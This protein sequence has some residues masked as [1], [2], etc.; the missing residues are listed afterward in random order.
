MISD[1]VSQAQRTHVYMGDMNI[2]VSEQNY[3]P[4]Q[5]GII[6]TVPCI[7][8]RY[9]IE[10]SIGSYS[11]LPGELLPFCAS[12]A[13]DVA[14]LQRCCDSENSSGFVF[15]CDYNVQSMLDMDEIHLVLGEHGCLCSL[16]CRDEDCTRSVF[17]GRQRAKVESY[18]SHDK[19]I[20]VRVLLDDSLQCCAPKE[21]KLGLTG[22]PPAAYPRKYDY[23]H[24]MGVLSRLIETKFGVKCDSNADFDVSSLIYSISS[25][26]ECAE[27]ADLPILERLE[28]HA[29]F[30]GHIEYVSCYQ[31]RREGMETRLCHVSDV[32]I[33]KSA[34]SHFSN[35]H[36]IVHKILQT[37]CLHSVDVDDEE[38]CLDQSWFRG[39][40][41]QIVHCAVCENHIGWKFTKVE[42]GGF[43]HQGEEEHSRVSGRGEAFYG[44][45]LAAVSYE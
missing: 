4:A 33:Q 27:L 38:P 39:F 12:S 45:R 2:G 24:M 42:G 8:P 19:M 43:D 16:L 20:R 1:V 9:S 3:V 25:Y 40:A 15:I 6:L 22:F 37:S 30:L 36:R 5:A 17:Y 7:Y 23:R 34:C 35:P 41:W 29:A 11:F 26:K 32:I 18:P 31:C 13:T 21:L 14:V 44:I 28:H 10:S